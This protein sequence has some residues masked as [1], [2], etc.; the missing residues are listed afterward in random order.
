MTTRGKGRLPLVLEALQAGEADVEDLAVRFGVSA[1]TI[2]RDLQRLATAKAIRR[3][4]GGALIAHPLPEAS[5][6]ER[7]AQH[8]AEKEAI[9]RAAL[10]LL[11]PEDILVLDGGSTVATFGAGLAGRRHHVIT[12]NLPLACLLAGAP[13]ITLTVLGGAV[14]PGSV[15]T[16]GPLAE[17]AL[18]RLTADKAVV[19]GDGFVAGRGLCEAAL[20]QVALKSLM[21]DQAA[22]VVVLMD[23]SKLGR[24]TQ[25]A[26]APLPARWT[27]VTDA[28]A[29]DR[30]CA[31]A[32]AAGAR[33][34][35]AP[36]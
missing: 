34:I 24:A 31:E 17:A 4:Y 18:R 6:S 25:A 8:R 26:W 12:S 7:E 10:A 30:H 32:E 28:A 16:V 36:R 27:L 5:L 1:S 9:A 2:R 11:G 21:M 20:D 15:T 22:E 14:R 19:S 33:V 35:R 13:E 29:T 23:S 3:T